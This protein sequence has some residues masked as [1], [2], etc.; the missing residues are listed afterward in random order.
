MRCAFGGALVYMRGKKNHKYTEVRPSGPH[1]WEVQRSPASPG[2]LVTWLP[3]HLTTSPPRRLGCY[4]CRTSSPW[5]RCHRRPPP[6][7]VSVLGQRVYSDYLGLG[8]CRDCSHPCIS[9]D[10]RLYSSCLHT[11]AG[12]SLH[13]T[14]GT[15]NFSSA[16]RGSEIVQAFGSMMSLVSSDLE[17]FGLPLTLHRV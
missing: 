13:I 9:L 3:G 17:C 1:L 4:S 12:M 10:P 16:T 11:L 6:C 5:R 2:H 7:Y 8:R 14:Y 15:P